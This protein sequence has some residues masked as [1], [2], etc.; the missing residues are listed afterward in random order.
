MMSLLT[1]ILGKKSMLNEEQKKDFAAKLVKIRDDAAKM[2]TLL[3]YEKWDNLV[4]AGYEMDAQMDLLY[5]HL[6]TIMI[7]RGYSL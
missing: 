7:E 6:T 5:D 3:E 4:D 1:S 2:L